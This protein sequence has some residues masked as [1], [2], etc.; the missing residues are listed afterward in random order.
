MD[1]FYLSSRGENA[2]FTQT[3]NT[4]SLRLPRELDYYGKWEVALSEISIELSQ[5]RAPSYI[6]LWTDIVRESVINEREETVLRRI[7]LI[8]RIASTYFV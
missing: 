6:F 3:Q 5:Q 2:L 7:F 8:R 1:T 4:L